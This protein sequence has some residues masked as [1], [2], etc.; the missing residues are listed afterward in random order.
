MFRLDV[1][2]VDLGVAL[3]AMNTYVSSVSSVF[4]FM[5]QMFHLDVS[6]VDRVLHAVV[7]LLLMV[8]LRGSCA[9]A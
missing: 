6:K 1:L 7:R 2:K 3:V 4:R 8:R 9:G 5:L